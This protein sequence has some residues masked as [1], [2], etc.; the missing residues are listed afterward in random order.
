[1][2]SYNY[3][4]TAEEIAKDLKS[5]ITG[6][7]ILVTGA[8][9]GGLGAI[10]A[11]TVA[12]YG[13]AGIILATRDVSKAEATAKDI[14]EIAP[15]VRT[16][17]VTLDLASQEQTKKAVEEI[18]SLG[19]HI[20][21]IVNNAGIMATPYSKTVDGIESQ[22]GTNHIGHFL[23]T[24]LLL[25]KLLG[26]GKPVRVVNVSSNG[27]RFGGPRFEDWN[28]DDGKTYNR[29][30]SYGQS[31]SANMLFSVA[32]AN[33]LG[34]KGLTSVSLHPGV[35][36][37]GL[38]KHL[39]MEDFG[40]FVEIDHTLGYKSLWELNGSHL[41]DSKVVD[42][43]DIVSWARDSIYSEKLWDLSEELVGQKFR[44]E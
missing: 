23:L 18:N 16:W 10:F 38:G 8:S 28:F 41:V 40:E 39:Q 37:T 22:F 1:M 36:Y 12:K 4:T 14:A 19:Q 13:P 30:V 2:T 44:Y 11:T 20:D 27:F 26:K 6:Q 42:P 31:K 5:R 17:A 21:V 43:R 34:G 29:W 25:A 33:K 32:L 24:N 3:E 35:I 15:A 7:T 9:P